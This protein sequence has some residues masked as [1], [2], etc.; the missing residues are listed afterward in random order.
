MDDDIVCLR[1]G[2]D[3]SF[4]LLPADWLLLEDETH[5]IQIDRVFIRCPID[6]SLQ[7][8][9]DSGFDTGGKDQFGEMNEGD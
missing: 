6:N 2:T 3:D 5:H 8:Q 7:K 1:T 4:Q 9:I